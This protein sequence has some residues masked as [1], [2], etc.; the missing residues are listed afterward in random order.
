MNAVPKPFRLAVKAVILDD[1]RRCLLIRRSA[2]NRNFVGCWEWPGGKL[3]P[4]EDFTAGLAREVS[5]ECGLEVE[6]TGLAGATQFA[7]PTVNVVLL[8]MEARV[9]GGEP[10]LSE[11]HDQSAWVPLAELERWTLTE[12][13]RSFILD[14]AR[15]KLTTP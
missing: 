8:C 15:R 6:L 11:E 12:H 3:D 10:S 5:E 9:T 13:V 7:M 1:A 4:G 14:Y 2:A